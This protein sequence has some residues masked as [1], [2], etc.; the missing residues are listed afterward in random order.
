MISL[1]MRVKKGAQEVAGWAASRSPHGNP[2]ARLE[3]EIR[4]PN[5]EAQWLEWA[6]KGA[7]ELTKE[8]PANGFDQ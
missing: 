4:N 7:K 8:I 2:M 6:R 5:P 3:S 1:K